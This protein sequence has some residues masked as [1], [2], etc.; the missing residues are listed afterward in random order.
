M[1]QS[2]QPRAS[3][4]LRVL[5]PARYQEYLRELPSGVVASFYDSAAECGRAAAGVD[6]LWLNLWQ[7]DDVRHAIASAT[8]VRW[9][10]THFAGVNY[11]PL[12][13]I[14]RRGVLLTSGVGLQAIAV[15]EVA[16]LG[17]LAASK[18]WR[19]LARAQERRVWLNVP[20]RIG[21]LDGTR[22]LVIG[23]GSVGRA[24]ADRLRA[25][26]I[27]VTGV[28][29]HPTAEED[30]IGMDVWRD[31]LGEF[32]WVVLA[33]PLTGDT[34]R[35]I[36]PVELT[37]MKPG[38][39][40]VNI[41]RGGLVDETALLAALRQRRIGGA[42]LDVTEHEPLPETSALWSLENVIVTPHVAGSSEEQGHRAA[43]LFLDNL[44]RYRKGLPLLNEVDL[45]AGY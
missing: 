14:R 24:V 22:A 31:R 17:I 20:P 19:E 32:D 7:A 40:L 44:D 18:S 26:G 39:W 34:S 12:D 21:A 43:T 3:R 4:E 33:T 2:E 9:I 6:V 10:S 23:Y 35:M 1:D 45:V 11:F 15:A 38:A 29:R 42:Y 16:L 5:A 36:G 37:A 13:E 8:Q 27:A 25:F 41:A 30:V 28:R